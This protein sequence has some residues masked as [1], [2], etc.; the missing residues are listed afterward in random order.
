MGKSRNIH[1]VI[2]FGN[3][4]KTTRLAKGM[5]RE[6]VAAFA[7]IEVMQLYR[8]ETGKINTTISTLYAISKALNVTPKKLL[9]FPFED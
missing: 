1:Y 9:D 3:N 8:I 4:L 7:E 6:K 2:A 5:S